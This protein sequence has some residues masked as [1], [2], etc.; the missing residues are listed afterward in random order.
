MLPYL[1]KMINVFAGRKRHQPV[2]IIY[3]CIAGDA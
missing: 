1:L 2:K 3:V